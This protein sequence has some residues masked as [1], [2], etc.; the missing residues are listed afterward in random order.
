MPSNTPFLIL[1]VDDEPPISELLSL[2]AKKVFPEAS[3]ISTTSARETMVYLNDPTT[4]IPQLILLDI[5]LRQEV[6]GL[7]LLP[8][9]RSRLNGQVPIIIFSS[10]DDEAKV[11]EAY[12]GGAVSF[13]TKPDEPQEWR[14][15]VAM[16][17]SYWYKSTILPPK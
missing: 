7:A 10:V 1:V 16:L 12:S 6:D 8:R 14:D 5:D 11:K 15:Y 13:T 4:T 9:L 3:F 17:R 2:S